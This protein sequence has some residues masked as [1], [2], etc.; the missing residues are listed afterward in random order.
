MRDEIRAVANLPGIAIEI[1]HRPAAPGEGETIG[2][3]IRATPDLDTAV[4]GLGPAL[5]PWAGPPNLPGAFD[6]FAIWIGMIEAAWRPWLALLGTP[7]RK[8]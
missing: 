8:P 5:L 7:K 1:V 3:R 2:I 4:R 6:P